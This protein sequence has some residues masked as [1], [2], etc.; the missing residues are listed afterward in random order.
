MQE[1]LIVLCVVL[2]RNAIVMINST[3]R[4]LDSKMRHVSPFDF[5]SA[6]THRNRWSLAKNMQKKL[7]SS[8]KES[9]K[10]FKKEL[11]PKKW[12]KKRENWPKKDQTMNEQL[13][14]LN[15]QSS[16]RSSH[17][18]RILFAPASSSCLPSAGQLCRYNSHWRVPTLGELLFGWDQRV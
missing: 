7:E 17:H 11:E 13:N 5:V 10:E 18:F 15:K 3:E 4:Q 8:V 1:S 16:E 12:R 14:K 6:T 9:L 2:N